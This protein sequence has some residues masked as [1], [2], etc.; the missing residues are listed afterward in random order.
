MT[1]TPI[2]RTGGLLAL[3]VA[4]ALALAAHSQHADR[5]ADPGAA[6]TTQSVR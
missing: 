3:A 2:S 6:V 5:P 4:A 1:A